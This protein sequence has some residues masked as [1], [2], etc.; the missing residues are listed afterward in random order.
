MRSDVETDTLAVFFSFAGLQSH[1]LFT[2]ASD[3][4]GIYIKQYKVEM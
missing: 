2:A 1:S 4:I 3:T